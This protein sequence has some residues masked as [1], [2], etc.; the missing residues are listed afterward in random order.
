MTFDV[1]FGSSSGI[2]VA[3]PGVSTRCSGV[4]MCFHLNQ[5]NV[6]PLRSLGMPVGPGE[7]VMG[8]VT[9]SWT[10]F[11]VSDTPK[12]KMSGQLRNT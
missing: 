3:G 12:V 5:V 10:W 7:G 4:C 1:A 6:K 11:G 2:G 8:G 9:V